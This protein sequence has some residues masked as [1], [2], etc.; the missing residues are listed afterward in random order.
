MPESSTRENVCPTKSAEKQCKC[1]GPCT[2]YSTRSECPPWGLHFWWPKMFGSM[3]TEQPAKL[4]AL[5]IFVGF[6]FTFGPHFILGYLGMPR[7]YAMYPPE[8][9]MLNVMSP[10]GATVMGMGHLLSMM[11][12][13]WSL[14]YGPIAP[15]NLWRAYGL[16][17]A[18]SSPPP[19]H[20]FD[21]VPVVTHEAHDYEWMDHRTDDVVGMPE[22][23]AAA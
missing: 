8:W 17:W 18:V 12:L 9:Q 21:R 10:A 20:N 5:L 6:F 13:L 15:R 16:E 22:N 4:A 14:K 23:V 19:P 1:E 7:R 3:Y 2:G 11:Y